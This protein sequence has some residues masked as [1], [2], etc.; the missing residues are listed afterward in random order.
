MEPLKFYFRYPPDTSEQVGLV[1]TMKM[2][3]P[4][5]ITTCDSLDEDPIQEVSDNG[6]SNNN[7]ADYVSTTSRHDNVKCRICG[8]VIRFKKN[9]ARHILAAHKFGSD[10]CFNCFVCNLGFGSQYHLSRHVESS[11]CFKNLQYECKKC[12][13]KFT[14]PEKLDVH[15]KKNCSKKYMCVHCLAFFKL[16]KD[17]LNHQ[18]SHE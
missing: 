5:H 13:K 1:N 9:M 16:K 15:T 7:Q 4:K 2:L 17:F 12:K 8:A 6:D 18:A 3:Q 11:N 14:T 10:D